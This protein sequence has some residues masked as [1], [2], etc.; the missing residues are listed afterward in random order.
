VRSAII[1]NFV[2]SGLVLLMA[3]VLS[4]LAPP[5]QA[6]FRFLPAVVLCLP[7]VA[8]ALAL[9]EKVSWFGVGLA[10]AINLSSAMAALA[11]LAVAFTGIGGAFGLVFF[12]FPALILFVFNTWRTGAVFRAKWWPTPRSSA[13]P[14]AAAHV[15]P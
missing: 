8:T 7:L 11:F 10:A 13:Q 5:G 6:F 12:L 3:G 14:S 4:F 9:R 2:V 1:V 15:E